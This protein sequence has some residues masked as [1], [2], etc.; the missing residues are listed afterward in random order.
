MTRIFIADCEST[1]LDPAK[2]QVIELAMMELPETPAAFL[3]AP[4]EDLDMTHSL[5]S[6]TAPM[7]LGAIVAHGI[8]PDMLEGCPEF[9]RAG[10]SGDAGYMIGHNVD[11]DAGFLDQQGSKRICTLAIA[12]SMWPELD[13]HSQGAVLHHVARLANKG[14]VWARDLNKGAHRADADV[15]NCARI[16]KYM[17]FAIARD[18]EL[19]GGLS[20]EDLYQYSLDCRIPKIM[21]FGKF[22]GLP[23]ED[24]EQSW[25]EWYVKTDTADPCV[26]TA[27]RRAGKVA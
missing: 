12:R 18:H 9:F 1:G 8:T 11:F 26:M 27:L 10:G 19:K 2:D 14:D 25:A 6:H 4:L 22:K 7:K 5:Y 21:T 16:L 17:I 13:S 20:W 15:M 3:K 23:V 24:V